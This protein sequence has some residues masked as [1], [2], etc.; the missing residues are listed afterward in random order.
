LFQQLPC[1]I[2]ATLIY[3]Q[4]FKGPFQVLDDY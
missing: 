2:I 1:F 3:Y 4:Y